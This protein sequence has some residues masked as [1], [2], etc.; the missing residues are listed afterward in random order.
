MTS[1]ATAAA[2]RAVPVITLLALVAAANAAGTVRATRDN[3][4]LGPGSCRGWR[5]DRG[6]R[7]DGEYQ[8]LLAFGDV[9][10]VYC[11]MM[12]DNAASELPEAPFEYITLPATVASTRSSGSLVNAA[13]WVMGPFV[14]TT[15]FTRVRLDADHLTIRTGDCEEQT[16]SCLSLEPFEH[17]ASCASPPSPSLLLL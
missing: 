11:H 8:L 7:Q 6:M 14:T 10:D 1:P 17:T 4:V 2:G 16:L 9:V 3:G 15:T 5:D 13:Q 12:G